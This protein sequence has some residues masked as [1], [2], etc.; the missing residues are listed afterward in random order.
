MAAATRNGPVTRPRALGN[1]KV[2]MFAHRGPR[3]LIVPLM[4]LASPPT[5]AIGEYVTLFAAVP[6]LRSQGART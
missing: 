1:S 4:V 6:R 3:W 5:L 2:A